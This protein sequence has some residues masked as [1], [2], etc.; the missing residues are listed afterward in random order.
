MADKKINIT[1]KTFDVLARPIISEKAARA[2]ES[3]GLV[4]EIAPSATK[5]EVANAI[6]AIYNVKPEK[7]NIVNTKGKVKSFR[8]KS[9]GQQR[10]IKKAYITLPKGQVIDILAEAKIA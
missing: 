1:A 5:K 2:A 7:I 9:R 8:G 10:T 4:F 3:N 6:S